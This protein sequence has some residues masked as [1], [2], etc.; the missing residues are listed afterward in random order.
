V[1]GILFD[2]QHGKAVLP[3]QSPDCVENLAR[4]QRREAERGF[5]SINRRGRLIS[6]RPIASI[7]CSPPDKVPRAGSCA[8]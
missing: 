3:V 2:D 8:P 5:V 1:I 4:D 6:A 7:C